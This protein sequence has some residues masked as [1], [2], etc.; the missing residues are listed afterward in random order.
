MKTSVKYF[1]LVQWCSNRGLRAAGLNRPFGCGITHHPTYRAPPD[2][3][4]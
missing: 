3:D 4:C 1:G 2:I